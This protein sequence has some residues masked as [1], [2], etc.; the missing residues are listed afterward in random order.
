MQ[1]ALR[2]GF[3]HPSLGIGG[4][5]RL[6]IDAALSL[7]RA[8]HRVTIFTSDFNPQA[9]FEEVR[10]GTLEVRAFGNF[11]PL[12]IANRLRAPCMIFRACYVGLRVAMRR[13]HFDLIFVDVVSQSIAMLRLMTSAKLIFYCH[14]P[15]QLLDPHHGGLYQVY[16]APINWSEQTT[17]AMA[18]LLLVNSEFTASAVRRV[19]PHLGALA[20]QVLHPGVEASRFES[21]CYASSGDVITILSIG[22]F[23]RGKNARLAIEAFAIL[24]RLL[25]PGV[26][27][28]TRLLIAGGFDSRIAEGPATLNELE[29]AASRLGVAAQVEFRRS[30][31]DAELNDLL[32][33]CRC[34]VHT[35]EYEPF[36]Y[37]PIEAMAAGRPVVA[38]NSGGPMETIVDGVTGF[39]RAPKADEFAAALALLVADPAAAE[40][41]GKAAREHVMMNF[42]L[43]VFQARLNQ[44]VQNTVDGN[45]A[46]IPRVQGAPSPPMAFGT[47][48]KPPNADRD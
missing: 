36:G 5:E 43:A 17:T 6:V 10:D 39:L 47:P 18:D 30:P 23:H 1:R 15:D 7:Q 19:F 34:L 14:F 13:E 45:A 3:V 32:A 44:M 42:S 24:E 2:I 16:R 38:T 22:R 4:A 35:A 41:M 9:C 26:F 28:R 11:L 37:A 48:P 12:H 21:N 8:G 33:H 27:K 40:R 25:T 31:S 46:T 20:P 29:T